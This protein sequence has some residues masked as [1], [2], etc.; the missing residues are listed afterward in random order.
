MF[1]FLFG[2][3]RRLCHNLWRID[4]LL[5]V[6]RTGDSSAE[7]VFGKRLGLQEKVSKPFILLFMYYLFSLIRPGNV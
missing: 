2:L 4:R 7:V 1:K 6:A 5:K 3:L